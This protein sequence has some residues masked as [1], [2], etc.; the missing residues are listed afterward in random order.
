VPLLNTEQNVAILQVFSSFKNEQFYTF[1]I[2]QLD[3][4][5]LN[6]IKD[7][8]IYQ[9]KEIICQENNLLG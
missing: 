3:A 5:F 7:K 1:N 9:I 2:V 6:D 4:Q 8:I